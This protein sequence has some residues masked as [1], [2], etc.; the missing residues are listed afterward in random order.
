MIE[1]LDS[2][3]PDDTV[4]DLVVDMVH[5]PLGHGSD[6]NGDQDATDDRQ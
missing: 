6:G 2:K 5:D 3:I 4:G 1:G